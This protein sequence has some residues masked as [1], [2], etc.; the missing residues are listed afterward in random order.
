V[1]LLIGAALG[2]VAGLL[3]GGS[4]HSLLA[5]RLR[6]PLVVL[7][8]FLVRELE[9]RTP[10]A[11][12]SLAPLTFVLSLAVL[13]GWTLWHRDELPGI[14]LVAAGMTLNLAVALANGG[15]MPVVPAAAH[16]GPPQLQEQGSWAEYTLMGEDTRLG[17]LGDWI[18]LP[19]PLGRL[20][21]Q[22]YSPG[23]MV[24][25]L[26]ITAVLFLGTRPR[27]GTAE[28]RAITTR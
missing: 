9:V 17:W 12:S 21:P 27:R 26:G 3:T 28:Q 4:I 13:I 11:D 24:S 6:W 23:D 14:W 20:L 2:L 25:L 16:L 10:L 7:A 15:H 22:A 8:A 1:L 19:G 5:R 18:T